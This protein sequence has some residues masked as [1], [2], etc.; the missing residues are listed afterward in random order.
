MTGQFSDV[1]TTVRSMRRLTLLHG[2]FSF[3][4]KT[5]V[6]AMSINIISCGTNLNVV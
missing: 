4:F 6:L 3:F 5:T 2:V 1:Q